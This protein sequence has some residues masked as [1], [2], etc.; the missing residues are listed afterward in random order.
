[1]YNE[2]KN[3]WENVYH[4]KT[5]NEVS[6]TQLK[7]QTSLKLIEACSPALSA[8][9]IDIGGG[10]SLLAEHLL[11][12]G[13]SDITV[14]DI[15]GKALERAKERIGEKAKLVT[16][17]ESDITEFEPNRSYSIWH[18]RATFHF[19][20][21]EEEIIRYQNLVTKYVTDNVL[22]GTFSTSGP[23]KCSG[24]EI[25]QY[26]SDSL[27]ALFQPEFKLIDSFTENHTT[28]FATEQNFV[29]GSFVKNKIPHNY[30]T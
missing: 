9:I 2:R 29:F 13:F 27:I 15:S 3:H 11:E 12:L 26:S 1:M 20:T 17:I 25:S 16:W 8:P 4:T 28:P 30:L 7:P 21:N 10:D 18:D 19:L 22:I 23:L 6:W 5:P 24:L 14:L